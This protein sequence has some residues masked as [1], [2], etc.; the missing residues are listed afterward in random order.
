M[1]P[2]RSEQKQA[3]T[4]IKKKKNRL[5]NGSGRS[6]G[7]L[8]RAPLYA[9][10]DPAT[11]LISYIACSP[12]WTPVKVPYRL[13]SLSCGLSPFNTISKPGMWSIRNRN[14]IH[15]ARAAWRLTQFEN[16]QF[17]QKRQHSN[18]VFTTDNLHLFILP[19]VTGQG[20]Q[21]LKCD[22]FC[23]WQTN[24]ENVYSYIDTGSACRWGFGRLC[25]DLTGNVSGHVCITRMCNTGSVPIVKA[26]AIKGWSMARATQTDAVAKKKKKKKNMDPKG[27]CESC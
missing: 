15:K 12:I 19:S 1:G 16:C 10:S 11:V 13:F 14:K 27:Y 3:Y 20:Q 24:P 7:Y 8:C 18:P 22:Q 9:V 17:C 2:L 5:A 26:A 23:S 6:K 4:Y 25:E 21:R